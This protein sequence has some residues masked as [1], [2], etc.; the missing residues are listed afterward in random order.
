MVSHFKIYFVNHISTI[1]ALTK[2]RLDGDDK[3]QYFSL[4][5]NQADYCSCG[6]KASDPR[7]HQWLNG[8]RLPL[9]DNWP[10]QD[11][12]QPFPA[13]ML[14]TSVMAQMDVAATTMAPIHWVLRVAASTTSWNSKLRQIANEKR[15]VLVMIVSWRG[16]CVANDKDDTLHPQKLFSLN[17]EAIGKAEKLL[18]QATQHQSF[19][20]TPSR[21]KLVALNPFVADGG[22]MQCQG[23]LA[24]MM[25]LSYDARCPIFLMTCPMSKPT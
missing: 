9:K 8:P 25:H 7:W 10:V 18:W 1:Q 4:A 6:L 20:N 12:R 11:I 14:A 24:H 13:H 19:S 23:W 16:K 3:W 21:K 15:I 22:L 2:V 17:S 5:N